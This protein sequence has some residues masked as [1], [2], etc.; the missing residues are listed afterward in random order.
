M[1][2]YLA[3]PLA[4][5][6]RLRTV[7][8]R[9]AYLPDQRGGS[10]NRGAR[11]RL[12]LLSSDPGKSRSNS[13]EGF[14]SAKQ[15]DEILSKL[16]DNGE[17]QGYIEFLLTGVNV[18]FNEK[19]QITQTFGDSETVYYFGKAPVFFNLSGVL[20]DSIDN[21]WFTKFVEMYSH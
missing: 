20:I 10:G 15:K 18:Q 7:R 2:E 11:S 21:P 4:Q 8:P 5:T 1:P 13:R 14:S 16:L 12:K 17:G 6:E 9:S 3:K 19:V